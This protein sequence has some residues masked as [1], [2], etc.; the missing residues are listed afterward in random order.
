[1]KIGFIPEKDI[2]NTTAQILGEITEYEPG[3]CRSKCVPI[4]V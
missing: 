1:M 4:G 3:C 2:Q